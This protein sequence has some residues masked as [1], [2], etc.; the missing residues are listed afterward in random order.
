[1]TKY[2]SSRDIPAISRELGTL[3]LDEISEEILKKRNKVVK[4]SAIK[5]WFHRHKEIKDELEKEIIGNH[6]DKLEISENIFVNGTFEKLKTVDKWNRSMIRKKIVMRKSNL[7]TLKSICKGKF[8]RF[9]VPDWTVQHPDRLT[10]EDVLRIVDYCIVNKIDTHTYRLTA[11]SFLRANDKPFSEISGRKHASFGKYKRMSYPKEKVQEVLQYVKKR[12]EV[13]YVVDLFMYKTGTR[14]TA[15]LK[16]KIEDVFT[17]RISNKLIHPQS[18]EYTDRNKE[19]VFITVYDKAK[20]SIHP[21]GKDWI[22]YIPQKLYFAMLD[23]IGS[24]RIGNIFEIDKKELTK[25]NKEALNK[26]IPE[27]FEQF[28]KFRMVNHFFRHMFAQNMLSLTMWNLQAVAELGGWTPKALEESY[29]KPP[30]EMVRKW[31][32]QFIPQI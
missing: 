14:V 31:G 28:P 9:E 3:D 22:K 19:H 1:M 10:Q 27:L 30:V 5:M 24:R 8:Q 23:I 15:T 25:L 32:L 21:R 7:S 2:K 16:A 18:P 4:P 20:R 12:N 29:G 26:V 17:Q 13:A 6:I 11:R